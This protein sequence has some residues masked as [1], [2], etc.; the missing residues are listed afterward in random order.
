[1]KQYG[2]VQLPGGYMS[3][4]Y[5]SVRTPARQVKPYRISR[6]DKIFYQT[7]EKA[8]YAKTMRKEPTEAEK[9][10]WNRL[11]NKQI[12]NKIFTRQKVI[13]G[14]IVDFYCANPRLV[15]EVDGSHHR[16]PEQAK[17]D[18]HRD[19]ALNNVGMYVLRFSND[20]V[21]HHM[22]SVIQRIEKH[23]DYKSKKRFYTEPYSSN[24]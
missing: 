17:Y 19:I 6:Q 7:L 14:Y 12:R 3:M 11:K 10:L 22:D 5:R 24:Y 23:L 15:I 4:K 1:M 18:K 21:L 9:A 20:E 8:V 2:V 16:E 13:L